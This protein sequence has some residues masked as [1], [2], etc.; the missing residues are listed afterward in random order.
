MTVVV[1]GLIQGIGTLLLEIGGLVVAIVAIT[2]LL[3][4]VGV[5][6][7][8]RALATA[9]VVGVLAVAVTAEDLAGSVTGIANAE[10][11]VGGTPDGIDHCFLEDGQ[12]LRIPFLNWLRRRIPPHAIYTVTSPGEPD[13]WCI[14]LSLRP[15]LPAF[16]N[17]QPGWSI[18]L[19][20]IPPSMQALLDHHDPSVTLYASGMAIERLGRRP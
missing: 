8:A 11:T 20:V 19:G 18:A 15:R 17:A 3:P 6:T 2:K 7:G 14:T 1:S 12:A 5:V 10:R 4:R 16:A 9:L 13:P